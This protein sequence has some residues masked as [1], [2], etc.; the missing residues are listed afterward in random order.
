VSRLPERY[1]CGAL[2]GSPFGVNPRLLTR[3]DWA[4]ASLLRKL[5]LAGEIL[6][7]HHE[8]GGLCAGCLAHCREPNCA[9]CIWHKPYPCP[10]ATIAQAALCL[11]VRVEG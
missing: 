10:L 9:G 4:A 7:E 8:H 5:N 2:I 11:P 3:E 1:P 6:A